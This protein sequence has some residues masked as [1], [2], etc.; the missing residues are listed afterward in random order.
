MQSR[1]HEIDVERLDVGVTF[2]FVVFDLYK[3]PSIINKINFHPY[4]SNSR[5]ASYMK[6]SSQ[7]II[8]NTNVFLT[9]HV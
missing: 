3:M 2:F 5:K 7:Q 8:D 9:W 6:Y 4:P 1:V